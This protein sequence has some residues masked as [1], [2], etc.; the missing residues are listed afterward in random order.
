LDFLDFLGS[1]ETNIAAFAESR[2]N[3]F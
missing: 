2:E 3:F 1:G